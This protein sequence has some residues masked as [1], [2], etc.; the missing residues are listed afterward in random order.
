[1]S[2]PSAALRSKGNCGCSWLGCKHQNLGPG[3]RNYAHFA[4]LV[5]FQKS[6]LAVC[7]FYDCPVAGLATGESRVPEGSHHCAV[8][9][10]HPSFI[11]A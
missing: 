5:S 6:Y 9:Q 2:F 4:S 1:M 10:L 3:T 7:A 8:S 11:C